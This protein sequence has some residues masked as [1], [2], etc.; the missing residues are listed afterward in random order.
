MKQADSDIAL[1][2]PHCS[3]K[4][5][6]KPDNCQHHFAFKSLM[7]AMQKRSKLQ[8]ELDKAIVIGN[9]QHNKH[10]DFVDNAL[11]AHLDPPLSKKAK[12]GA[13]SSSTSVTSFGCLLYTSDAA[14][15]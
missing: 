11:D 3:L 13:G 10:Q 5:F 4:M 14:D 8:E 1:W 6:N 15:E 7:Q 2:M 9:M 12:V